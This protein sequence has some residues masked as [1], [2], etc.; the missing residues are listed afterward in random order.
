MALS[1]GV[2]I[3]VDAP[4]IV[5]GI[6]PTGGVVLSCVLYGTVSLLGLERGTMTATGS[7]I[8]RLA[9]DKFSLYGRLEGGGKVP[10]DTAVIPSVTKYFSKKNFSCEIADFVETH[11]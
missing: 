7:A 1:K 3:V 2:I 9:D 8:A 10:S 4:K 5:F 6:D 11:F